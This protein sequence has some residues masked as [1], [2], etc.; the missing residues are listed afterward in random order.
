M[1]MRTFVDDAVSQNKTEALSK[2]LPIPAGGQWPITGMGTM[3]EDM[4]EKKAC[5]RPDMNGKPDCMCPIKPYYA[6]QNPFA[7]KDMYG[8]CDPAATLYGTFV[9]MFTSGSGAITC[10]TTVNNYNGFPKKECKESFVADFKYKGKDCVCYESAINAPMRWAFKEGKWLSYE[11]NMLNGHKSSFPYLYGQA[12]LAPLSCSQRGFHFDKKVH[13][14]MRHAYTVFMDPECQDA[15]RIHR[16]ELA[17]PTRLQKLQQKWT[18]MSDDK[19]GIKH[20]ATDLITEGMYA[21]EC[22]TG[23]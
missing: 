22:N 10:P 5:T 18:M 17:E 7:C 14:C 13:P 20:Q 4:E 19:D 23:F 2:Q 12:K 6:C 11:E 9:K 1:R 15:Y 3:K 16:E 21:G 8:F